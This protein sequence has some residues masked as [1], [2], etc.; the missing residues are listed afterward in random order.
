MECKATSGK[1]TNEEEDD[2]S[3]D[4]SCDAVR[5]VSVVAVEDGDDDAALLLFGEVGELLVAPF[6]AAVGAFCCFC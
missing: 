2:D 4:K 1:F 6:E 5:V 3:L